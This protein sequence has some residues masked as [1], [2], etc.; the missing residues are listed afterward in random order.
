MYDFTVDGYQN[1]L[2]P[3]W[4]KSYDNLG[5]EYTIP[6]I[7][8][9]NSS[10]YDAMVVLASWFKTKYTLIYGHGNWGNVS[11]AGAAA[12]RY[13]E[14]RLTQFAYDV[15]IEELDKS[16][17]IVDWL[18]NYKRDNKEPEYL[19][20]KLPLLLINGAFGIGVGM[21]INI[22]AH[23]LVEV[24]DAT[25]K[26]LT[27]PKANIVLIPDLCQSCEIINSDWNEISS[28]GNGSFRV[29]GKILTEQDKHGNYILR[30]VS[31]PDMVTCDE[32]YSKIMKFVAGKQLPMIKDVFNSLD[33]DEKPDIEIQLKAGADPGYVK[34][35]IYSNT[36]V[37]KNIR[38]NFE[39]VAANGIDVKRFSYKEYLLTFI[40]ERMNIKFRLYCNLLQQVMTRF[41]KIDAYVKAL[42][43]GQID[44][45]IDLIRKQKSID[46]S[47]LIEKIIKLAKVTDLQAKFIIH[48]ELRHLAMGYLAQYKQEVKE[49][50]TKID[51]YM[52]Y[53]TD[54]G[55]MIKKEI[56][57]ELQD[58]AKK[59]GRPRICNIIDVSSENEIPKGTFK[60][61]VTERNY[62]RK[63]PDVDKVGI[64]KKD[65][66]KFILRVDNAETIL[67]FDNKGKVFSL[68]VH[69]IPIT[70]RSGVGTDVRIL[71]KGLTS[72][73]IS[74]FYKP[75][76]EKILK[77]ENK[78][79][80]VILSK[81]N[82]I[83]KL[84]I[85]DLINVPPSG[86]IYTKIRPEDEV[87]GVL[88]VP[89][90]L[91]LVICS[92]KKALRCKM[93][94]IPLL[95]RNAS[96]S[97]AMDTDEPINGISAIYP[98]VEY[99]VVVTKNGKFNKFNIAM[100]QQHSR[101]RKG[102]SVIKLDNN[103]EIFNIFG[104]ND[105]DKIRLLTTE[106]VEEVNVSDIKLKS[107]IAAGVKL[108]QSRGVIVR[109][110]LM[111][112]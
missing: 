55:T 21:S 79:Y 36:E 94:D 18:D 28:T 52:K 74:V 48:A 108:I 69:K 90:N 72:D 2:V 10:L 85:E 110:D 6:M 43:S 8:V 77:S 15:L 23:N 96:G 32:V 47:E 25:R 67:I 27:N 88:P 33:K 7:S 61:I 35:F 31:L 54:D 60:I 38:V 87:V 76:F 62:I 100:M 63:I 26:L 22:P 65:N 16:S 46:E 86:L 9:H 103:D 66:P 82:V 106:G 99:I 91:D 3:V 59:Y 13:T 64:V 95:K 81:Q 101:G 53:V 51:T 89:H 45:I 42:S 44:K 80:L 11:G 57:Q 112:K 98:N 92:G 30:I 34:Q 75:I 68:P 20:T 40:D 109:A 39:V 83:K 105:T 4:N 5:D 41:H 111:W 37:E 17:N 1:M 29:R 93:K 104:A 14:C 70:D 24:V 58:L 56:D 50:Q 49:L 97:K 84:D 19:P 107:S 71:I 12:Q 78:H 102:S 73:I